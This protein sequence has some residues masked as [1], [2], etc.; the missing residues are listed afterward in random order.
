MPLSAFAI[1]TE[2]LREAMNKEPDRRNLHAKE[3]IKCNKS[4]GCLLN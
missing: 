2:V 4:M 3:K 1:G